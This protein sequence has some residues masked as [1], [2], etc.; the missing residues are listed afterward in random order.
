MSQYIRVRDTEPATK[1]RF[2][3]ESVAAVSYPD[4]IDLRSKCSPIEDQR[5]LG[6]CTG[7][8]IV[9]ALEYLENVE[10]EDFVRLSRLFVYY[11][12]RLLEDTTQSDAGAQIADGIRVI[13]SYGVCKETLWPYDTKKFRQ[14]PDGASYAEALDHKAVEY[15]AVDQTEEH[16]IAVLA[17]RRP[18]VFGIMVYASF[19]SDE[20]AKT[21][22][23]PMP[24]PNEKCMGGH[25]VL[26]VGYD[27]TKR[28]FLVRNSWGTDWGIEG[29]FWLPFDFVLNPELADSF[30]TV[31]KIS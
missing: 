12:E 29:Y 1:K 17:G 2:K 30:Y 27:R 25:A 18:I 31:E 28:M 16:L 15:S 8:A 22:I 11:N 10:R 3:V 9:G 13:S 23:V 24:Q 5:D 19:E 21:G 14:R 20:V 4:T 6:A 26:I 7:H